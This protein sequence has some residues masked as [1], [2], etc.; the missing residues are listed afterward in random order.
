[1]QRQRPKSN[2]RPNEE[3]QK[4]LAVAATL[5]ALLLKPVHFVE[6]GVRHEA[7]S[8]R[9]IRCVLIGTAHLATR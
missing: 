8:A 9:S 6:E 7:T 5:D 3:T 2:A 4:K 1:M